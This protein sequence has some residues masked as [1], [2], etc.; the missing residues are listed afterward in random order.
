DFFANPAGAPPKGPFELTYVTSPPLV[1]WFGASG[2]VESSPLQYGLQAFA[3]H[4]LESG[5]RLPAP[6]PS[7]M[8]ETSPPRHADHAPARHSCVPSTRSVS[9]IFSLH[10]RTCP[11][12]EHAPV[13]AG[14]GAAPAPGSEVALGRDVPHAASR[15]RHGTKRAIRRHLAIVF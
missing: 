14:A 6:G 5:P 9:L 4:A 7:D 11:S 15:R 2:S 10:E 8:S 3:A 13:R 12:I 1:L